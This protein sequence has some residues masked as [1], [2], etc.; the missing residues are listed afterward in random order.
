MDSSLNKESGA[1]PRH[2]SYSYNPAILASNFQ[3][4]K[5]AEDKKNEKQAAKRKRNSSLDSTQDTFVVASVQLTAGGLE[6][7]QLD[8]FWKR[9]QEAVSQA[10]EKGANVILLPELFLGPYFCQTQEAC[11]MNLAMEEDSCFIIKRMK[12]LAKIY[13]VVLPISF[14]ERSGNALY[15]SV[16][17]IDADG[18][19]LGKY[20]KVGSIVFLIDIIA[21]C[22]DK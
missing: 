2:Y 19:I 11:L 12:I 20:R 16:V 22:I 6:T 13:G 10:A 15:N 18:S 7:N 1:P 4:L 3:K 5:H 9:A 14:F 21:K 17:V 8:G